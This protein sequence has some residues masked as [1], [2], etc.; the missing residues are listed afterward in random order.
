MKLK[1]IKLNFLSDV[2]LQD[3]EMNTLKGG[4]RVCGCGCPY[5]NNGGSTTFYNGTANVK[6]GDE[7]GT[8]TVGNKQCFLADESATINKSL[9]E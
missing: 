5:E 4:D 2:D 3:R 9:W 6:I 1:K 8:S 7:G